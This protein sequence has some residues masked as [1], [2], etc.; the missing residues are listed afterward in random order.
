MNCVNVF[1][2]FRNYLFLEYEDYIYSSNL[3]LGLSNKSYVRTIAYALNNAQYVRT[4]IEA[5]L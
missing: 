4:N 5:T 2:V 3:S 1:V